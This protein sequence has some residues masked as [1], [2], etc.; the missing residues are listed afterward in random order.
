MKRGAF[1]L[2]LVLLLLCVSV[3]N[4][5][6]TVDSVTLSM[7]SPN[8]YTIDNMTATIANPSDSYVVDWQTLYGGSMK[9][10][11]ELLLPFDYNASS[12]NTTDFSGNGLI[13]NITGAT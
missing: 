12:V 13:G 4:A 5:L 9:S 6:P 11:A 7:T 2:G 3:V 1:I 8:N 10:I